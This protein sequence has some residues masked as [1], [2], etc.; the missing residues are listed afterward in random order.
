M[1]PASIGAPLEGVVS[2]LPSNGGRM[3]EIAA[4]INPGTACTVS[5]TPDLELVQSD[6][7]I[8]VPDYLTEIGF[9]IGGGA[10]DA[11]LFMVGTSLTDL[12]ATAEW[13]EEGGGVGAVS[14]THLTL[15]TICSV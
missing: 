14:Y 5:S 2:E 9:G 6:F 11:A 3:D 8:L 15:P 10:A 7:W 1:A 13:V 12:C 4:E